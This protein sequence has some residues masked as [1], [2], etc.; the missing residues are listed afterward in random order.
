MNHR[1]HKLVKIYLSEVLFNGLKRLESKFNGS[2][3]EYWK[4]PNSYCVIMIDGNE[5]LLSSRIWHELTEYFSLSVPEIHMV[6]VEWIKENLGIDR[7]LILG[8]CSYTRKLPL[9]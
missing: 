6:L 4:S 1:M 9:R 8:E 5:I 3:V 2:K 7:E